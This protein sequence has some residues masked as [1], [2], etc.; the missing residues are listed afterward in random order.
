ML[1]RGLLNAVRVC[2]YRQPRAI[3]ENLAALT[4]GDSPGEGRVSCQVLSA[5]QP[6]AGSSH[7]PGGTIALGFLAE[8]DVRARQLVGPF[9]CVRHADSLQ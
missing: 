8:T 4:R 2:L 3:G 9:V 1:T 7:V 5:C 6:V